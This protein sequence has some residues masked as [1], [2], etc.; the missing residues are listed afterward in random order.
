[1]RRLLPP[2]RRDWL[3]IFAGALI[4]GA[5]WVISVLVTHSRLPLKPQS[6]SI[7]A[8]WIP[9]TVKKWQ[10]PI[11]EMAKKYQVDPN[12][13]AIVM[14][15]ES[16]G[17]PKAQSAAGAHGLMQITDVTAKDIASKYLK[18]PVSRNYDLSNPNDNIEFG[19][20]YLAKLREAFGDWKQGPSWDSTVELVAAG[21]NGGPGAANRIYKGEGLTD[22][23]TVVYS[24]D[25]FNMW[26]E[27]FQKD[28]PTYDRWLERGGQDLI[29]AAK[30]QQQSPNHP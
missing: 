21:Y 15:M 20:A 25:A 9:Q 16:G 26:R 13:I 10:A 22:T 30:K 29:D 6:G 1:M 18:K 23:Q 7:T 14:T 17:D 4:I 2:R 24:R 8:S 19:V 11:D 27:R 3:F 5:I 12:L 28:S